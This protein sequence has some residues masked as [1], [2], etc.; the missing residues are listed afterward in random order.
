MLTTFFRAIIL[1]LL[2]VLTMRALGK[3]QLG[4]FQPYEFAVTIIIA[5]LI[6]TPIGD[7]S[8]PLLQGV[9][10]VAALLILHAVISLLTF[11]SDNLRSVISGRPTVIIRDGVIDRAQMRRLCLTL[12]DLTEALRQQGILDPASVS[13]AVFEA[14]GSI[15]AFA[16]GAERPPTAQEMQVQTKPDHLP[17]VLIMDGRLQP[18]NLRENGIPEKW[19]FS[20]LRRA[21][22][23]PGNVYFATLNDGQLLRLQTMDGICMQLAAKP[24]KGARP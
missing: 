5:D 7:V 19:L 16:T 2:M 3:R 21:A 11:K 4:Q 9:L 1:Y 8:T 12:S 14:N 15:S 17:V 18:G 20:Q 22:L 13:T 24:P 10:P 23:G 6:A